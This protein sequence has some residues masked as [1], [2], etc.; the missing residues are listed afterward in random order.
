M[1][2]HK[3]LTGLKVTDTAAGK[4]QA[5][6]ATL[7]VIDKDG[8][9][10]LPGE[11]R[12][13][14]KVRISA[15][16]HTSWD[17]ALPVGK[18]TIRELGDDVI[19]DGQFFL[20]TAAGKDTFAVV[21]ELGE[22]GEWSYGFDCERKRGVFG[23]DDTPVT[24]LQAIEVHEVSPVLLGAGINTRTLMAKAAKQLQS[25]LFQ[26][27]RDAGRER[28]ATTARWVWVEDF[29]VDA[30]TA[31]YVVESDTDSRHV[32]VAYSRGEAGAIT[33]EAGET[34]VQASTVYS[35]KRRKLSEHAESVVAD[36][37]ALV[38]RVAD[39]KAARD[40]KGKALGADTMAALE[41]VDIKTKRLR[42]VLANA[43]HTDDDMQL[44]IAAEA[45]RFE[46]LRM[47]RTL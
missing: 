46:Q 26:R 9:V 2:Q 35:P 42:D 25:D 3:S 20:S 21:Q 1:P 39:V 15:Y 18:G 17:G 36:L 4:V 11:F 8:D 47:T 45:A 38:D 14:Q 34:E 30:N 32:R 24:F 13:G 41:Q 33:L 7:N 10:T 19:L 6:F 27:L 44:A 40:E 16:N 23:P 43:P 12:E 22:L 5:V 37:D 31:I 28:W 29:D